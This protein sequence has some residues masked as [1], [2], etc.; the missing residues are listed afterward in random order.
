MRHCWMLIAALSATPAL[1]ADPPRAQ[2]AD[3]RR[4]SESEIAKILE[5]AAEKREQNSAVTFPPARAIEGEVG[6]AVGSGGYRAVFGNAIVPVGTDGVAILS[7]E[8]SDS[9]RNR[10]RR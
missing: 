4:L 3:E 7:I 5:A 8:S 9:S 1:A 10:R 2:L 6:V